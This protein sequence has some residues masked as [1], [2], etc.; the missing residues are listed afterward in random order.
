MRQ[1]VL[2]VKQAVGMIVLMWIGTSL[3]AQETDPCPGWKNP[4]SFNSGSSLCYWTARVGERVSGSDGSTGSK[5]LSTCA[6][7]LAKEIKGHIN[8]TSSTLNTGSDAGVTCCSH[9]DVWDAMDKRFAII[10]MADTGLDEFTVNTEGEGMPRI[11]AGY[12]SCI[13][14]GDPRASYCS[15]YTSETKWVKSHCNKSSEA[16]FYTMYVTPANA[17]LFINYAVVGRCY[18]HT[19]SAAGEFLIR[20][21]RQDEDGDWDTKPINDSLWF[22]VSAPAIPSSN[23]PPAPWKMGMPG[24]YCASTTCAYVYK[25]WTKVAIS[26]N[27]FLYTN[28][29]VEIYTSDCV[30][31]VDPVYA[32]VCG[33]YSPMILGSSGCPAPESTVIDTLS[34]P[35]G[36]LTYKWYVADRGAVD[37]EYLFNHEYMDTV[38][39]HPL[40]IGPNDTNSRF[41]NASMSDFVITSGPNAGDTASTQTFMCLMTSAM[42]PNKPFQSKIYANVENRR[43][44]VEFDYESL[45]DGTVQLDNQ[46]VVFANSGMEA[47]MTHWVIY[48]DAQATTVLDTIWGDSPSYRFEQAGDYAVKLFCTTSGTANIDPCTAAK[49]QVVHARKNPPATFTPNKRILCEEETLHVIASDS[50]KMMADQLKLIWVIDG[51]TLSESGTEVHKVLPVGLHIVRLITMNAD[52]CTSTTSEQVEVMGQPHIDMSS[53]ISAICSGDSVTLAVEGTIEF[54][55]SSSPED[56]TL[57]TTAVGGTVTV[58]PTQTTTYYLVP[59]ANT[60]CK[61]DIAEVKV[62]VVP[63]P[64]PTI[65]SSSPRVNKEDAALTLQD[66]S[67]AASSSYWSF[68]DGGTATGQRVTHSFTNLDED[69]VYVTLNSCNRLNCCADSTFGFPVEVTTTWFP[70]AFTPGRETNNQFGIHTTLTLL[71]YEIY[72]YSRTGQLIWYTTDPAQKWDGRTMDG[73]EAPTGMY[74]YQ[75]RYSYVPDSYHE[76]KGSVTLIR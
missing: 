14:L 38:P 24:S 1:R 69:S 71:E 53:D 11:P 41:H 15:D 4:T 75:Y 40:P 37:E 3:S 68:S 17:L 60:P 2:S 54:K 72:I 7:P 18:D 66:I 45:C 34:A 67:E 65:R 47:S 76:G 49:T 22:R 70:N 10:T 39:F 59:S 63:T 31:K 21:V 57:D 46:S 30:P 5:V 6:S 62:E 44:M 56:P 55:W 74:A 8:I 33:D 13:R 27:A 42:D 20:V 36:M 51:D 29:R 58:Y 12:T 52:S 9:Q 50:V 25:P 28:V 43:P 19:P 64:V 16:L 23:N 35:D 61:V 73:A 48:G 32:Y 26:L